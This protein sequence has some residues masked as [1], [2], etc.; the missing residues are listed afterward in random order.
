MR[1]P[2]TLLRQRIKVEPYLGATAH[3][4]SWGP[5]MSVRARVEG[6]RRTVRKVN[7]GSDIG[8]DVISTASATIRPTIDIPAESKVTAPNPVSGR[9]ETYEVLDVIV[10]QGL[11]GPV[12]LELLLG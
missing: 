12:Y 4:P 5:P 6:K 9:E 3:G 11:T 2:G 10:G 7:A 8:T 1:V